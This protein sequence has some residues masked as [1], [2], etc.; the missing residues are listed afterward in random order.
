MLFLVTV[1]NVLVQN[2]Q[3][4]TVFNISALILGV[5]VLIISKRQNK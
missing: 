1:I 4:T 5:T 3:V 2:D